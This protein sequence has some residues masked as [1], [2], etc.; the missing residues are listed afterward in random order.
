L[1]IGKNKLQLMQRNQDQ[2]FQ[3]F[4]EVPTHRSRTKKS[5]EKLSKVVYKI[6]PK[7]GFAHA[8]HVVLTVALPLV[9]YV[10]IRL[11]FAQLAAILILLSKWRMFSVKSRHW[12][13]NIRANAVD[14]IV[15]LSVVLF[16]N[17]TGS[18]GMQFIWVLLYSIWLIL[19]KPKSDVLWVS[20]QAMIGQAM[21]LMALFAV[22]GNASSTVLVLVS[23]LVCYFAARHFFSAF[24]ESLGRTTAYVWAYFASSVVWLL[25]HWL[26]YYGVIA[27]PVLII[28]V[29]GYALA[30]LYYLR[31]TD[32]LSVN[33]QRQFVVVLSAI[34]IILI[35]FSDWGDKTI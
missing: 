8:V 5:I 29:V 31:H 22:F 15:G 3:A 4:A 21:G 27:Q 24:D 25:S 2:A 7:G 26:I 1:K 20:A 30:G 19:I 13:A 33:V 16:M 11:D 28:S 6:K 32:K 9:L 10:L 18:Q 35:V 17:K 14:I 34:L 12:P 23:T